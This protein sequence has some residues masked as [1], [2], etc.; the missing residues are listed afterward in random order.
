MTRD[1]TTDTDDTTND[2][3]DA[4]D[5]TDSETGATSE[6]D[7]SGGLASLLRS[8]LETLVEADV[9]SSTGAAGSGSTDIGRG[10]IGHE[11]SIGVG[12]IDDITD[13]DRRRIGPSDGA[14]GVGA[15]I[16]AGTGLDGTTDSVG[17]DHPT[18]VRYDEDG[19]EA[20]IAVDVPEIDP[21]E[22]S[23]GISSQNGDLLV[24]TE[25]AIA[26]RVSHDL[27]DPELA[28]AS[29]HNAVLEVH[30]KEGGDRS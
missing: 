27:T 25:A 23:A 29:Y 17:T 18:H 28:A 3:E 14:T 6:N 10:R 15:G 13:D 8:A 12:T 30:L 4:E 16:D 7:E 20:I 1:D 11:F 9:D 2:P 5:A 24:G 21:E 19:T 22:L 26:E